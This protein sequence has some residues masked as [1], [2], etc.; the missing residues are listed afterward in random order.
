VDV[1]VVDLCYECGAP[2]LGVCHACAVKELGPVI[3]AVVEPDPD[4]EPVVLLGGRR[5]PWSVFGQAVGSATLTVVSCS[6]TPEVSV[7]SSGPLAPVREP[8]DEVEAE[9]WGEAVA[10]LSDCLPASEPSPLTDL[11]VAC[12]M[13]RER[14][15]SGDP[16]MVLA[17]DAAGWD[18][19]PPA[20]DRDLWTSAAMALVSVAV[21]GMD[22]YTARCLDA[23]ELDD[24]LATMIELVRSGCGTPADAESL[25]ALS[26][27]CLDI[28]SGA[29]DPEQ[30]PMMA[31]AFDALLPIWRALDAVTEATTLTPLGA[32]GLPRALARA[33][34]GTL[35]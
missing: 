10:L 9:V 3:H 28:D 21:D 5:I 23:M 13:A 27:R 34:A 18:G 15:A 26:A 17:G 12:A 11:A 32:W 1:Q 19:A 25:L 22:S 33:W 24:W 14:F 31:G 4:G 30:A 8:V 2:G 16:A 20:D 7:L 29:V 35:G 6:R